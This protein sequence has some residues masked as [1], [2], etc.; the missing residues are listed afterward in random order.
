MKKFIIVLFVVPFAICAYGQRIDPQVVS[1]VGNTFKGNT[2]TIDWTLGEVAITTIQGSKAIITQGFHQPK[3]LV[4]RV[5]ALSNLTDEIQVYP[6][7]TSNRLH[8]SM[9][10]D[11]IKSVQVWLTDING[12]KLWAGKYSGQQITENISLEELPAGNYLLN[13]LTGDNTTKQT[14]KIIKNQ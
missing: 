4:T 2:M 9:A 12:K 10:F 1:S 3:Y 11:K 7:P 13:C 8:V 6:N 5:D 14:F